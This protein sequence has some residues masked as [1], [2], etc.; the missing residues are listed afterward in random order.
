MPYMPAFIAP[1]RHSDPEGALA[2][3]RDIYAQQIGHLRDAMQR[4]VSGE[5]GSAQEKNDCGDRTS[6]TIH[7]YFLC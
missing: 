3:V 4:F 7:Q 2:Q 1:T 5:Y 6:Q